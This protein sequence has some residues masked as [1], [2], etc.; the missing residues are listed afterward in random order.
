MKTSVQFLR[1]SI[2]IPFVI[3]HAW[4]G[5]FMGNTAISGEKSIPSHQYKIPVLFT[6]NQ[7]QWNSSIRF[8][9]QEGID[10][11]LFFTNGFSIRRSLYPTGNSPSFVNNDIPSRNTANHAGFFFNFV[12]PER[13][14]YLECGNAAVTKKNYYYGSDINKWKENVP[15]Y[16]NIIYHN[17]WQ[18]VDVAISES[19]G[20]MRQTF[21]V[22]NKESLNKILLNQ[23]SNGQIIPKN[24]EEMQFRHGSTVLTQRIVRAWQMDGSDTLP[25]YA[26]F[27]QSGTSSYGFKCKAYRATLPL[28]IETE[29]STF[30]GGSGLDTPASLD[31]DDDG[32]LYLCGTTDSN[33]FPVVGGTSKQGIGDVD[34]FVSKFSCDGQTLL[35]CTYIGGKQSTNAKHEAFD[36]PTRLFVSNNGQIYVV[37]VTGCADFP[38]SANALQ[39]SNRVIEKGWATIFIVRISQTGLFLYGSYY[40]DSC[41]VGDVSATLD[42]KSNLYILFTGTYI[43]AGYE[44]QKTFS[45]ITSNAYSAIGTP[46][47]YANTIFSK[48]NPECTTVLYCSYLNTTRTS[49]SIHPSDIAVDGKDEIIIAGMTDGGLPLSNP[50][51]DTLKS[52]RDAFVFKIN[53]NTNDII[54]STYLGGG[55][56]DRC[57]HL[58]LDNHN[59]IYLLISSEGYNFPIYSSIP[60]PYAGGVF[61]NVICKL[62][63]SG[64]MIFSNY[65]DT[66]DF[67]TYELARESM[68]VD[69]CG[70]IYVQGS[71]S[72][73]P[74]TGDYDFPFVNPRLVYE[75]SRDHIIQYL[76]VLDNSGSFYK[77]STHW[78]KDYRHAGQYPVKRYFGWLGPLVAVKNNYVY[79]TGFSSDSLPVYRAIQPTPKDTNADVFISK[80]YL[81]MCTHITSEVRSLDSIRIETVHGKISPDQFVVTANVFNGET[82]VIMDS[83]TVE[84]FLPAG[85]SLDSS[86]QKSKRLV[87]FTLPP[88]ATGSV[89]WIVHVDSIDTADSCLAVAVRVRYRRSDRMANSCFVDYSESGKIVLVKRYEERLN[90]AC[91]LE[92]IDSLAVNASGTGLLPDPIPVSYTL[93][94]IDLRLAKM[95][96]VELILPSGMATVPPGDTRRSVAFIPAGDSVRLTW[97][98]SAPGPRF[99]KEIR[100][101]VVALDTNGWEQSRCEKTIVAPGIP[102][103]VTCDAGNYTLA[104]EKTKGIYL[105]DPLRIVFF[106]Q[107]HIDTMQTRIDVELVMDRAPHLDFAPGEVQT[108]LWPLIPPNGR[109]PIAWNLRLRNNSPFLQEQTDT[110]IFRW[111]TEYDTTWRTCEAIVRIEK[112]DISMLLSCTLSAPD[113]LRADG[114]TL[115]GNPMRIGF[116]AKNIGLLPA[117]LKEITLQPFGDLRIAILDPPVIPAGTLAVGD[118]LAASWRVKL[119]TSRFAR[120][121]AAQVIVTDTSGAVVLI[122]DKK[123]AVEPIV[124]SMSCSV[125][126]ADTLRFNKSLQKYEPDPF[127]V[128]LTLAN[129]LDTV[130]TNI[131]AAIDLSTARHLALYTGGIPVI[132]I[133]LIAEHA[134]AQASWNLTVPDNAQQ[135]ITDTVILRFRFSAS[136]PWQ[137]CRY[138]VFIEAEKKIARAGCAA[139]GP[140]TI[141]NVRER[142]RLAPNPILVRYTLSNTGTMTLSN[143]SVAIIPPGL[144]IISSGTDSVQAFGPI[145]YGKSETHE[146]FLDVVPKYGI[147]TTVAI[148]WQ[149]SCA[150]LGQDTSCEHRVIFTTKDAKALIVTPWIVHFR[151]KQNDPLPSAQSV[152]LLTPINA[153]LG[154]QVSTSLPW[155]DIQ[156]TSGNYPASIAFRPNTTALPIGVYGGNALFIPIPP[157]LSTE[158]KVEY[159]IYQLTGLFETTLPTGILLDQNYPNPFNSSTEISFSIPSTG[160]V[161]LFVLDP[162]GREKVRLVDQEISAGRHTFLF[163][164]KSLPSGIYFYRLTMGNSSVSRKMCLLK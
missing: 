108:K 51:Q 138:L 159:E 33:D 35:F 113:T 120:E 84:L 25:I 75:N 92:T 93:R 164:T 155:L 86:E 83:V 14:A 98:V 63:P 88:Q 126:G 80:L 76:S 100:L 17:I 110:L 34:G 6:P 3:F 125:S 52:S 82:S 136:E 105:P 32:N 7:G 119:K 37:G 133:P 54:F 2:L 21:I 97:L 16:Y 56:D 28:F 70:N 27:R 109:E 11:A 91:A 49:G 85:L 30:F 122:C 1:T 118:S 152:S 104:F 145:P 148:R 150:E 90:L 50:S 53:I 161:S 140:D 112:A 142:E 67:T 59:N 13:N 130:Q 96:T 78:S 146:W 137:E 111:R 129:K 9:I 26:M 156:P 29:F 154:W 81:P 72:F 107:N 131:D 135:D 157:Y 114:D 106:L 19:H 144:F 77:F 5:V 123:F 115:A 149:W 45:R 69:T 12:N 151:A 41:G 141:W 42:Q 117:Q 62:S 116:S 38:V 55:G 102:V 43:S 48:L 160:K 94:N 132:Q 4:G 57:H 162:Y 10:E 103:E 24:A 163:N 71:Y 95:Q 58:A 31:V 15:T 87:P 39:F 73:R 158:V 124:P 134:S 44:P 46:Q 139:A 60:L 101:I 36:Y 74:L 127:P 99:A 65:L 47:N 66:I 68:A 128:L 20:E 40:G 143:C 22:K 121:N 18:L 23:A 89:N 153:S 64:S 79:F 147:D 61:N 8:A